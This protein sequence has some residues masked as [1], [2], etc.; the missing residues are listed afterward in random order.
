M[1][2]H[3]ATGFYALIQQAYGGFRCMQDDQGYPGTFDE[4]IL[5]AGLDV[6]AGGLNPVQFDNTQVLQRLP[7]LYAV[8]TV[9]SHC[10][11]FPVCCT[12][13]ICKHALLSKLE[14]M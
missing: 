10:D 12:A 3:P 6:D 9:R 5:D 14:C 2:A 8:V 13:I 11:E 7:R 1:T 4:Y